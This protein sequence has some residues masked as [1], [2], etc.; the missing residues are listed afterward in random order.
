[1]HVP[2]WVWFVTV[3]GISVVIIADLVVAGRR[4]HAIG[5]REA[6]W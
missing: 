5:M 6:T 1:M 3:V 4:P 2:L